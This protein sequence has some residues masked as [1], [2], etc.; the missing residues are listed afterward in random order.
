MAAAEV[1]QNLNAGQSAPGAHNVQPNEN[2]V[3][4][5]S[6]EMPQPT[7]RNITEEKS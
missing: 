3:M 4:A 6:S 7:E 1:V 5:E 2:D